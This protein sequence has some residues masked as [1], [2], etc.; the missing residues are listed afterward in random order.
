M[1]FKEKLRQMILLFTILS[2]FLIVNAESDELIDKLDSLIGMKERSTN[3]SIINSSNNNNEILNNAIET[4]ITNS[5]KNLLKD[6][7]ATERDKITDIEINSVDNAINNNQ[8]QQQY[9]Q[10]FSN[11]NFPANFNFGPINNNYPNVISM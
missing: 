10:S 8:E 4:D 3:N 7:K 9:Q 6:D 11:S 1:K 5:I 2:L